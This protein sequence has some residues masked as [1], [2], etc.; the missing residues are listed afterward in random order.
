MD[1]GGDE[2]DASP[3]PQS[4]SAPTAGRPRGRPP[5]TPGQA[6]QFDT[7]LRPYNDYKASGPGNGNG[8]GLTREEVDAWRRQQQAEERRGWEEH[9]RAIVREENARLAI[10][11]NDSVSRQLEDVRKHQQNL[12]EHVRRTLTAA[13]PRAQQ[14]PGHGRPGVPA[15]GNAEQDARLPPGGAAAEQY[16]QEQARE[17]IARG[18]SIEAHA[19]PNQAARAPPP[20]AL[21]SFIS[22][23]G[24][25]RSGP[26]FF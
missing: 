4:A 26:V 18:G 1:P 5:R 23:G 11:L 8:W 2:G 9:Q 6:Q 15:S 17:H 20:D 10:E 3:A 14:A 22:G 21:V 13:P 7:Y 25:G 19:N 12:D 24:R 16:S